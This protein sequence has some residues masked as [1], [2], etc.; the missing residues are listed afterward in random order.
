MSSSTSSSETAAWRRFVRL[1]AGTAAGVIGFVFLF[2][3]IV[4]PWNVLPLSPK[5]D[6]A[7]VTSNQRFAYPGLARSEQ[8][9]SAV[10]GTSTSR[11]LRPARL[12]EAFGARFVNLAMNAATP[13]EQMQILAVFLRAHPE[14]KHI[15]LGLDTGWCDTGD[16]PDTLTPRPFPAWM[17][18]ETTWRGYR[19]ILNIYAMEE[20]GK[21]FGVLTGLKRED[22]GRDGYTVFVPPDDKWDRARAQTKLRAD[23]M[24]IPL[25]PRDGPPATWRFRNFEYLTE[26]LRTLPKDTKATLF[27][28]PAHHV[29]IVPPD[30]PAAAVWAECR[31]RAVAAMKDTPGT[32]IADFLKPSALTS[33]DDGYWDGMHYRVAIADRLAAGLAAARAGQTSP[34]YDILLPRR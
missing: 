3:A 27:F 7:P 32:T 15:L 9:D 14:A 1:A 8:F 12:N 10:I 23:G 16:T 13:W 29:R 2:V 21:E 31:R 6:R 28:V 19:E 22:Q 26:T 24:A 25:G 34:D 5:L 18:R 17:Y 33:D 4:D 30:H 20:A 11:L